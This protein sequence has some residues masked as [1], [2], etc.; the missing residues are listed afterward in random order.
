MMDL[1]FILES[2][3]FTNKKSISSVSLREEVKKES[4]EFEVYIYIDRNISG[5]PMKFD[6]SLI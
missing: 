4:R 1:S 3:E 2:C 6:R 5:Y